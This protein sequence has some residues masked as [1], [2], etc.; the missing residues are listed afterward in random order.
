MAIQPSARA[1]ARSPLPGETSDPGLPQ[2]A[3]IAAMTASKASRESRRICSCAPKSSHGALARRSVRRQPRIWVFAICLW[4]GRYRSQLC[5]EARGQTS[6][7]GPTPER[8]TGVGPAHGQLLL[9]ASAD[10]AAGHVGLAA[11][12]GG[13]ETD[14]SVRPAERAI[15]SG[16]AGLLDHAHDGVV[17]GPAGDVPDDCGGV[18]HSMVA[19][20][21]RSGLAAG[22]IPQLSQIRL[23]MTAASLP[24]ADRADAG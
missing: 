5:S 24:A 2:P 13:H 15:D 6:T 14:E 8:S 18:G 12:V 21:V 10:P 11:V 20:A 19:T 3:V 7:T 9:P 22:S 23:K 17:V 1:A 16:L 4:L